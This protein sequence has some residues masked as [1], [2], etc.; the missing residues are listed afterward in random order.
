MVWWDERLWAH[1]NAHPSTH[2][3]AS[4]AEGCDSGRAQPAAQALQ[5]SV[6]LDDEYLR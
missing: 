2:T 4:V 6:D 5:A 3:S 1:G